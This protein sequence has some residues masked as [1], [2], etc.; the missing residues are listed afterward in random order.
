MATIRA[1]PISL[2]QDD[3]IV[4]QVQAKNNQ[5]WSTVS[6]PNVVGSIVETIPHNPSAIPILVSQAET[7]ITV[8]M[9]IVSGTFTGGAP[10]ISYNL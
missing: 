5:G 1:S 8:T 2:E 6:E 4:V 10:L 9:P 7:S 3:K